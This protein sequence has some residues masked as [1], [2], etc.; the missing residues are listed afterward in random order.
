[1]KH[2]FIDTNIFLFFFHVS[3]VDLDELEKLRVLIRPGEIKLW[4]PDQVRNEIS[5]NRDSIVATALDLKQ[6]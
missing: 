3:K 2:V 6:A 4:I 1:M 5:R